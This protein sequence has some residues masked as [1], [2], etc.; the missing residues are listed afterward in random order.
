MDSTEKMTSNIQIDTAPA[1]VDANASNMEGYTRDT[2]KLIAFYLPQYHRITENSQWWGPGFTEWTNVARARPNF[3]GHYQPHLPGELGF[4]DLDNVEVMRE[5]AALAKDYGVHGF[6]FYYYWFSGRRIL[7]RPLDNF[8]ASNIDMPFCLCWANENWTRTWDGGDHHVLLAQGHADGDE[9][10]FIQDISSFL[11]DPRYIRVNG[12]PLLVIYRIKAFPDPAGTVN[13]WRQEAKRLGFPGLHIVIVAFIDIDD[14][15][16]PHT[17]GADA[18]VEFPPHKFGTDSTMS[19]N[20]PNPTNPEFRGHFFDYP[21]MALHGIRRKTP[22]FPFYRGI[23]PSWDNTPRRQ[24]TGV[25]ILN[26]TPEYFGLWLQFLRAW[27]RDVHQGNDAAF[28]FV[29]AWN[30]WGEGCHLEPDLKWGLAWLD[31]I[32]RSSHVHPKLKKSLNEVCYLIADEIKEV[33]SRNAVTPETGNA[34]DVPEITTTPAYAK[35]I[36]ILLY[37]YPALH[38]I[39]GKIYRATRNLVK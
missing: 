33:S 21:A 14:E 30:E 10:R 16:A 23:M 25:T 37:R 12:N 6:C 5:Q 32:S 38:K 17:F 1:S 15:D 28:I 3:D 27:N 24:N 18:V 8:L 39:A 19:T 31:E 9:E 36:S 26:S 29:N 4:Y 2:S 34:T 13:K 35:R 11:A 7:E 22:D 20:K